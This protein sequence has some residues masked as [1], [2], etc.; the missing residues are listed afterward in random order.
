MDSELVVTS[1]SELCDIATW[2]NL[3]VFAAHHGGDPTLFERAQSAVD[4]LQSRYPKGW[5]FLFWV[6]HSEKAHP[7]FQK[8]LVAFVLSSK[9]LKWG[10]GILSAEGFAAAAQRGVGMGA[11]SRVGNDAAVRLF[12]EYEEGTQWLWEGIRTA[13]PTLGS[14]DEMRAMLEK[15]RT[16]KSL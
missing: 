12:G 14:L 1:R 15:L 3:M 11:I 16:A 2:G 10:A 13:Y 7:E 6:L 5:G 9:N 4:A 8:R